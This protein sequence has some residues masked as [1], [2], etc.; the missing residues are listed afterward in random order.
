MVNLVVPLVDVRQLNAAA[1]AIVAPV[2]ALAIQQAPIV[3]IIDESCDFCHNFMLQSEVTRQGC[4][5]HRFHTQCIAQWV[6][7]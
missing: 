1:A 3:V 7:A 4:A 5:H 2:P 6:A